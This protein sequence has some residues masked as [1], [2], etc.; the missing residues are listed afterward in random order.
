MR[1]LVEDGHP[2]SPTVRHLLDLRHNYG[3]LRDGDVA[4]RAS[5]AR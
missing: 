4:A 3:E 1:H 5:W 2:W